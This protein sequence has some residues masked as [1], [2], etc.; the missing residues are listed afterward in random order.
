[1]FDSNIC[2]RNF[3]DTLL[4]SGNPV[5]PPQC[6][7]SLGNSLIQAFGGDFNGVSYTLQ[8]W[9]VTRQERI[10]MGAK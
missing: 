1:V 6:R 8:S 5:V 10:A 4:E 2:D 7:E 3:D 9:I